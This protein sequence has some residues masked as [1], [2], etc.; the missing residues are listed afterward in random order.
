MIAVGREIRAVENAKVLT[1]A[2]AVAERWRSLSEAENACRYA[3]FQQAHKG[4]EYRASGAGDRFA[5]LNGYVGDSAVELL[6]WF[7]GFRTFFP[8]M[9][10]CLSGLSLAVSLP[11]LTGFPHRLYDRIV[12]H[13]LQ[14][15]SCYEE[16]V[17]ALT[18]IDNKYTRIA[19]HQEAAVKAARSKPSEVSAPVRKKTVANSASSARIRGGSLA[20]Q[21]AQPRS[22]GPAKRKTAEPAE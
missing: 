8:S 19:L 11:R 18:L 7:C 15:D 12:A 1:D 16:T 21:P 3:D 14:N 10:L 9:L 13:S 17:D 22:K 20:A 5:R 4:L 2:F 6:L